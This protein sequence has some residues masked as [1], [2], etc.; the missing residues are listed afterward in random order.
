MLHLKTVSNFQYK[1]GI[2]TET[3]TPEEKPF[4]AE[5][6][7]K[8]K[9][10]AKKHLE[11]KITVWEIQYLEIRLILNISKENSG[12]FQGAPYLGFLKRFIL[13]KT[14]PFVCIKNHCLENAT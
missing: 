6:K 11:Y 5:K 14:Y 7:K 2:D 13:Y 12:N 4:F 1:S 8:N 9:Q 10:K 3:L